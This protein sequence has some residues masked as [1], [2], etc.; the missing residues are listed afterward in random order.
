MYIQLMNSVI[1][2][3][4]AY[5]FHVYAWSIALLKQALGLGILYGLGVSQ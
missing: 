3:M 2:G 1:Q 5:S 4:L